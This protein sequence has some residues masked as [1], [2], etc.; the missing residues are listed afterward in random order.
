MEWVRL[1]DVCCPLGCPRRD[2]IVLTG[3]D[4]LHDLP[5]E[6]AVVKCLSCGLMRTNP[7]PTPDTIGAYYPSDYGPY[8]NPETAIARPSNEFKKRLRKL[9]RLDAKTMPPIPVGRLVEIGCASGVYMEQM[10]REGWVVEG[11]EFSDLA[12]QLARNKGLVVQVATVETAQAPDQPVDVV[13]AWMVLEHLHNPVSAL[14]KLRAW[15]KPDGLLIASVPDSGSL[16]NRQFVELRYDLHLPNHLYH[17]SAST[18]A[19]VLDMSGWQLTRVFWQRNCNTLLWST[20][21]LARDK[22]WARVERAVQWLRTSTRKSAGRLRMLLGW[23][24]GVTR[25]SG[26][27][28]IWARPRPTVKVPPQ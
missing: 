18:I 15:I 9:L 10:H 21:Y 1:E 2:E 6:F 17:F 13:A 25:Q 4:R 24:L 3:R 23:V 22:K 5:G 20:E 11:I 7:R 12:A 16:L 28:E 27:M 19:K 26:R 14:T 8:K